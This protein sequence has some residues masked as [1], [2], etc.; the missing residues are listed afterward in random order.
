M[1]S[2]ADRLPSPKVAKKLLGCFTGD[3]LIDGDFRP[4]DAASVRAVK[5]IYEIHQQFWR[6]LCGVAPVDEDERGSLPATL[7]GGRN[8]SPGRNRTWLDSLLLSDFEIGNRRLP[9]LHISFPVAVEI[10]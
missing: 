3:H 9:G 8:G 5:G 4:D 1:P 7:G 2:L 6:K 10:H